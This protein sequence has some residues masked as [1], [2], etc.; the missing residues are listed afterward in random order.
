MKVVYAECARQDIAA[1]YDYIAS[2]NPTAAQ[3]VEDA[4]RSTCEALA[5][6]P[7]AAPATDEPNVRRA[8]LARYPYTIFYR[9][10]A[11]RRRVERSPA[12]STVPASRIS[13]VFQKTIEPFG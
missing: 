6:F 13:N 4:I 3:V 8:P 7:Y 12:S 1:I 9:V 10:D 11:E 2:S 5:E